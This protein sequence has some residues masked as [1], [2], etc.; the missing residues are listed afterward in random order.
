M[1]YN[2]GKLQIVMNNELQS[3]LHGD[4]LAKKHVHT[5]THIYMY[6]YIHIPT[7]PHPHACTNTCVSV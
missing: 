7:H 3:L 1:N 6:T 5:Y 4:P 2:Y